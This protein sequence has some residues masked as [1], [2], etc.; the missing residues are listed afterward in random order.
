MEY[1]VH[2]N[3]VFFFKRHDTFERKILSP[4]TAICIVFNELPFH[5]NKKI[6]PLHYTRMTESIQF[7]VK[8]LKEGGITP[9]TY[10]NNFRMKKAKELLLQ[11]EMRI[12]EVAFACGFETPYYF[13]NT[14]KKHFGI[15][16]G[17]WR[18][19]MLF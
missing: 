3:E 13:T 8:A 14:F 11:Q 4:M 17:A 12:S 19:N 18:K 7:L 15:S 10:L 5:S 16:S 6:A 9:I 2:Q 1:T